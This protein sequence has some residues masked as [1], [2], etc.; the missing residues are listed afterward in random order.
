MTP[1]HSVGKELLI[2][3]DANNL[4]MPL[5]FK[6]PFLG[7]FMSTWKV[8]IL[9][10][11]VCSG[12]LFFSGNVFSENKKAACYSSDSK[13]ICLPTV[14]FSK[15]QHHEDYFYRDP[16][17]DSDFPSGFNA[18][19]YLPPQY[20]VDLKGLH[21]EK[22]I[23]RNFNLIEFMD[24]EKGEYGVF[25]SLVVS[26]LQE[27]RDHL[28]SPLFVNSGYRSPGY[29]S[30]L[31]GSA[32]WS[33]HTFG[34]AVDLSSF[35]H[36]IEELKEACVLFGATFFQVYSSHVHC[37]WRGAPADPQ[38]FQRRPQTLTMEMLAADIATHTKIEKKW[39]GKNLSLSATHPPAEDAGVLLYLW[40]LK[41]P[42]G[43]F[44]QSTGA[45]PTFNFEKLP[46]GTYFI[47][48][49]VGG[50]VEIES[51]FEW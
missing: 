45:N 19:Q 27:M 2:T 22:P 50:F 38:F 12:F 43:A 37:D 21:P 4:T 31:A 6:K 9:Y 40:S 51:E 13:S 24:P 3:Q 29:N 16:H 36:S 28:A 44:F 48:V 35:E 8:V 42:N 5:T 10:L 23:S 7:D 33:R 30:R 46:R 17:T 39:S 49:V 34:D 41:G 1:I 18:E 25:S 11:A 14:S 32:K 15:I 26:F 47:S 20:L